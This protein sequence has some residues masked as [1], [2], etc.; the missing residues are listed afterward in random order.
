MYAFSAQKHSMV[1]F[2]RYLPFLLRSLTDC[3]L[4]S[5]GAGVLCGT[6]LALECILPNATILRFCTEKLSV[7]VSA[8]LKNQKTIQETSFVSLREAVMHFQ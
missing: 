8:D 6:E 2:G 7:T 5:S 4:S 3:F 1:L